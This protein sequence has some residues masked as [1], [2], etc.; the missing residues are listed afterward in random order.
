MVSES[1][2]LKAYA[3]ACNTLRHYSNASLTVRLAS[4]VQGIAILGA[5]AIALV[6]GKSLLIV[7]FPIGGLLFT[8]LLYR[9]HLGY[10]RATN[11]FYK[12]AADMESKFFEPGN[13]PI[14]SYNKEHE[15]LYSSKWGK[16][17][18]LNA[19]FTLIG[20]LF[21]MALLTSILIQLR[22]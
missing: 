11:S 20:T 10:F 21:G 19:P 18:T 15:K 9:F 13:R 7:G 16:T 5:W 12:I 1:D 2:Q 8:F 14:D 22:K 3:E 4:I 6:Q 17:F